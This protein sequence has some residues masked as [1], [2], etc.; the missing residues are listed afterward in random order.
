M[1]SQRHEPGAP[2]VKILERGWKLG[3][4]DFLNRLL[5]RVD[6]HLG[7]NQCA[8]ERHES[9]EENA[10]RIIAEALE[11]AGTKASS[12]ELMRKG[13]PLKVQIAMRLREKRP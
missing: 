10:E 3:A 5:D 9:E 7:E 13:D 12:F 2:E 4:E 11:L 8:Q 6:G 1:E